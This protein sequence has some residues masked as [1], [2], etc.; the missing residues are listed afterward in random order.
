MNA[1]DDNKVY[2]ELKVPT[3]TRKKAI[4]TITG[5][6]AVSAT[7]MMILLPTNKAMAVSPAP[8][9]LPSQHGL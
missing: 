7:T 2:P 4:Y 6:V 5:F 9:D 3:I 1:Q 8:P